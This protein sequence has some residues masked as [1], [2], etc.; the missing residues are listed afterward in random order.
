MAHVWGSFINSL[1]KATAYDRK[2]R[3]IVKKIDDI[4][5]TIGEMEFYRDQ[6]SRLVG[7]LADTTI[8]HYE[9]ALK[10]ESLLD[11]QYH[12]NQAAIYD[13]QVR[14]ALKLIFP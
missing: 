13:A 11:F 2:V 4:K 9:S 8:Q 7:D 1:G 5:K 12:A 14:D 10:A 6:Y 3:E